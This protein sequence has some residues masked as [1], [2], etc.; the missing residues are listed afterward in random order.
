MFKDKKAK[1]EKTKNSTGRQILNFPNDVWSLPYRIL[2]L[3]QGIHVF[4][5]AELQG[6]KLSRL[7][8]T[9]KYQ[10]YQVT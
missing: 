7:V 10:I 9:S 2:E 5:V 3:K 4:F 1:S 6:F 8:S